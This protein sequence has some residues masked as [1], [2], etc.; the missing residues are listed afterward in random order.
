[1]MNKFFQWLKTKPTAVKIAVAVAAAIVAAC[2]ALF[3]P[4][5]CS[6]VKAVSYGDGRIST[7]VHQSGADSTHVS[8]NFNK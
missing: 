5:S 1:M 4:V 6:S 2:I 8:I 3:P 7:S